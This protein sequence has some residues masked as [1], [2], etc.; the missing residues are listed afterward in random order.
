[1]T[2]TRRTLLL[3]AAA[4]AAGLMTGAALAKA[5]RH[6]LRYVEVPDDGGACWSRLGFDQLRAGD[7]FRLF[8]TDGTPV[9]GG[10]VCIALENA[11]DAARGVVCEDF[12]AFARPF[13]EGIKPPILIIPDRQAAMCYV[14]IDTR[15][16][17][18]ATSHLFYI[19][20]L[21]QIYNFSIACGRPYGV[22]LCASSLPDSSRFAYG[23]R[24]N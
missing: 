5:A 10:Q 17:G 18:A 2:A 12:E 7:V 23:L 3:G 20:S 24:I 22:T 4:G 21:L 19:S 11:R 16:S 15:P 1:M 6:G 8:E 14:G 13:F 9:D